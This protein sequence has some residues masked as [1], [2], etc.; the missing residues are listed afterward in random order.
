MRQPGD[1]PPLH[2][3]D[4]CTYNALSCTEAADPL[5]D[6]ADKPTAAGTAVETSSLGGGNAAEKPSASGCAEEK[7]S[8]GGCAAEKPSAGGCA[9]LDLPDEMQLQ[10]VLLEAIS[11][12]SV[13]CETS[14]FNLL[15]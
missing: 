6:S 1:P 15:K 12:G 14:M 5:E 7:Q 9:A 4:P 13:S 11:N 3:S 8:A 10:S 2:G